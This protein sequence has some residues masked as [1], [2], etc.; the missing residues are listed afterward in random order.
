VAHM[1]TIELRPPLPSNLSHEGIPFVLTGSREISD[2]TIAAIG[3]AL[4]ALLPTG[5]LTVLPNGKIQLTAPASPA[6]NQSLWRQVARIESIERSR[7]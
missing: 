2:D 1:T 3:A 7:L 4:H 5:D 6:T